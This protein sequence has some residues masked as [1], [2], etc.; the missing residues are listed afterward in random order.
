MN[1]TVLTPKQLAERWQVSLTK[2]YEDNNAGRL[3]HLP[4]NKNRFPIAAIE[5]IEMA[6]TFD[7]N[8]IKTARE[9]RLERELQERNLIIEQKNEQIQKLRGY[10]AELQ[11]TITKAIYSTE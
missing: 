5:E 4:G 1:S 9:R 2:V 10:L 11:I 7:K 6:S 8:N 3:P